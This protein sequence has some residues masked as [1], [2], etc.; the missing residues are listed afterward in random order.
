MI[1]VRES[2]LTHLFEDLF[3]GKDKASFIINVKRSIFL[4]EETTEV[5]RLLATSAEVGNLR[6]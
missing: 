5:M 2:K 3:W 4:F 1:P 6:L